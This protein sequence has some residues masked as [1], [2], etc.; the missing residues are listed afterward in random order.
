V[1][2]PGRGRPRPQAFRSRRRRE[3]RVDRLPLGDLRP[4][5]V[6]LL[7]RTAYLQL[8]LFEFATTLAGRATELKDREAI[9]RIAAALLERH[10]SI[11]TMLEDHGV[12]GATAMQPYTDEID[13]YWR[14]LGETA[15]IEAVL[16]L[17]LATGILD[18]FFAQLGEGLPGRDGERYPAL[19]Q[20]DI[21]HDVLAGLLAEAI[22][23]DRRTTSRL[24]LWGRRLVGDTLLLARSALGAARDTSGV[25]ATTDERR[26]EPVLTELIAAHTRRMDGLGLT[27]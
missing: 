10:T 17:H 8:S 16:T 22:A 25:P 4:E 20:R 11:V 14:R 15:W 1:I 2:W 5:P 21:G 3:Q 9:T 6:A 7:G 24:A 19:L 13:R 23:Q 12:D 27:A 26:V 18:D